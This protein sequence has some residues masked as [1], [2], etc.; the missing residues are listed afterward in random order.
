MGYPIITHEA[1]NEFTS[2]TA[3]L[4]SLQREPITIHRAENKMKDSKLI[5]P[6]ESGLVP[7]YTG[8]IP[9]SYTDKKYRM[10]YEKNPIKSKIK[11]GQNVTHD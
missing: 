8:H 11:T 9:G 4:N 2:D 5:Y 10:N 3:R 7:H 6:V 1:L